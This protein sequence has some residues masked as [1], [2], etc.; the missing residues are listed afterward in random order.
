MKIFFKLSFLIILFFNHLPAEVVHGVVTDSLNSFSIPDVNITIVNTNYGTQ[1]D[2][3]GEFVLNIKSGAQ[4]KLKFQRVGYD[5]LE[6][7]VEVKSGK[8]Y[9]LNIRLKEN[10]IKTKEILVEG[11]KWVSPT[12]KSFL[13]YK[14]ITP[15][16]II[17]SLGNLEDPIKSIQNLSGV[18]AR[19]DYTSQLFIRG[20]SPDQN[21]I[22]LDGLMLYNPY[23]FHF[24]SIG[25]LSVFN[26]DMIDQMNITI[27]GFSAAYGNRMSGLISIQSPDGGSEWKHKVGIN[28][29]S[30]R[31]LLTGP[32]LDNL[33]L[34][35]SV[36][37][38]YY[39][40]IMNSISN[41]NIIYPYFED[42]HSK[43]TWKMSQNHSLRLYG[44]YG[45]EGAKITQLEQ[46]T[47]EF[48]DHSYNG[49]LSLTLDGNLNSDFHYKVMSAYQSNRDKMNS[50]ATSFQ[51]SN[52]A[53]SLKYQEW[54]S[55]VQFDWELPPDKI[56]SAGIQYFNIDKK[57]YIGSNIQ[58]IYIPGY[59]DIHFMYEK[60]AAFLESHIW[61]TDYFQYKLGFRVDYY[62]LNNEYKDSPR[63]SFKWNIL[64][65]LS[66][67][68]NWS[69]YYQLIDP[70]NDG[71]YLDNY[72]YITDQFKDLVSKKLY[73]YSVGIEWITKINLNFKLD[74]YYKKYLNLPVLT[75]K[76]FYLESIYPEVTTNDGKG[77]STGFELQ[78][79]YHKN[80][81]KLWIGYNFLIS[82]R[83]SNFRLE[84]EPT[85]FDQRHW[86]MSGCDYKFNDRWNLQT[87]IKYGSGYP[88]Y[89]HIGWYKYIYEND[90]RPLYSDKI[91]RPYYFRWDV[92]VT[93]TAGNLYMYL[94]IINLLDTQN[95]D[96]S[97]WYV[98]SDEVNTTLNMG[99][100]YMFPRFPTFGIE[101][102][103]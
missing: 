33:F 77:Y 71:Y 3:N 90:Y 22:V 102:N 65:E 36:R 5:I 53:T 80:N 72:T 47:G 63:F 49:I 4:Y 27:G 15:R 89:E 46:F 6:K 18:N 39:D 56:L 103:F 62:G 78:T 30:S 50:E 93:Y 79:T 97:F 66:L 85:H 2:S 74:G 58:S 57:L 37:R 101:Y 45:E 68:G 60:W 54:T 24:L 75:R 98:E 95:Y 25:G 9:Y 55:S 61:L 59:T 67:S 70:M 44:I 17:S 86:V 19:H 94:E 51:N 12:E 84:W 21:A 73:Y 38:T 7:Q 29:H 23:R 64:P 41:S 40:W 31:Y 92:R 14:E 10:P 82:K 99:S 48:V 28:L 100:V 88:N 34:L 96:Q 76:E 13:G 20:S 1:T 11:E 69:I 8:S 87:I 35:T 43:M 91:Y 52:L 83:L 81:L 32:I 16:E 42:I 26:P